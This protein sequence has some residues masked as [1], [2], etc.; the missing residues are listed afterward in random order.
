MLRLVLSRVGLPPEIIKAVKG[1]LN[2]V[3]KQ[4]C[5]ACGK[6]Y[7]SSTGHSCVK[8]YF[9]CLQRDCWLSDDDNDFFGPLTWNRP[10][11]SESEEEEEDFPTPARKNATKS[12]LK[13][14]AKK[15]RVL[16]AARRTVKAYPRLSKHEREQTVACFVQARRRVGASANAPAS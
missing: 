7:V 8:C 5:Y 3:P 10:L 6:Y 15:K 9:E 4:I 1:G 2:L 13:E 16:A 11:E 14:Q 12:V